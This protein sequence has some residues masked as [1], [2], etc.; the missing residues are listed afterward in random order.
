M[1]NDELDQAVAAVRSIIVAER[2]RTGPMEEAVS[3]LYPSLFEDRSR[4]A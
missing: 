1:I 3:K 4:P 2:V